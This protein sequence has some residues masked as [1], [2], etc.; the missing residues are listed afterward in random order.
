M[1]GG[2][3]MNFIID[4]L[5]RIRIVIIDIL[6]FLSHHHIIDHYEEA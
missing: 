1:K 5:W 6:I 3:T 4:T 2:T